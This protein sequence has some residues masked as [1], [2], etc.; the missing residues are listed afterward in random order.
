VNLDFSG[1]ECGPVTGYFGHGNCL[2]GS[3]WGTEFLDRL[4]TVKF[5]KDGELWIQ[6]K[7][8]KTRAMSK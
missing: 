2:L 4:T 1:L 7:S 8:V 5:L 3:L 6:L